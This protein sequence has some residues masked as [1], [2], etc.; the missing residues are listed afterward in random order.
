M[1]RFELG[2]E[3]RSNEEPITEEEAPK[4]N[5]LPFFVSTISGIL[6]IISGTQ[7]YYSGIG[8]Y[9]ALISAIV[10]SVEDALVLSIVEFISKVPVFLASIGGF[11]VIIGGFLLYKSRVRIGKF[12]ISIGAGIGIPELILAL[13]AL[14]ASRDLSLLLQY[15]TTGW[16]GIALSIIA[17]AKAK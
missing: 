5:T 11:S 14:I 13:A 8:V 1:W 16:A 17:R 6:L 9:G 7:G 12:M 2:I 4:K 10:Q 15:Q 3:K